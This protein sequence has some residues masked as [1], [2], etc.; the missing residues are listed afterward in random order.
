[1]NML[2]ALNVC[3][4]LVHETCS[5]GEG[6]MCGLWSQDDADDFDWLIE[7]NLTPTDVTGPVSDHTTG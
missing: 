1:M 4:F 3:I 7:H 6:T 2:N 5:F